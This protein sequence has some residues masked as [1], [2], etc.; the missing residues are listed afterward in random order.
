V[1]IIIYLPRCGNNHYMSNV[2]QHEIAGSYTVFVKFDKKASRF[3]VNCI[4]HA[5]RFAP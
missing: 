3:P 2:K 4:Y 5:S 1:L